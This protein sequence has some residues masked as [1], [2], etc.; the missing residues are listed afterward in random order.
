MLVA[1]IKAPGAKQVYAW[2]TTSTEQRARVKCF[3]IIDEQE[4]ER[5]GEACR[6]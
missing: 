6:M 1:M 5:D 2:S 3:Q 4:R